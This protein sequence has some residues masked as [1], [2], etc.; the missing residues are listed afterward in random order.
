MW[1]VGVKLTGWLFGIVK[2]WKRDLLSIKKFGG[3]EKRKRLMKEPEG[4][5]P[6]CEPPDLG[7]VVRGNNKG[8]SYF[9]GFA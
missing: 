4:S 2:F 1:I 6:V 8:P 5:S 7:G 3:M 9:A